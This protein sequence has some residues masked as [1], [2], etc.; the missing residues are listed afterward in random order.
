MLR[1]YILAPYYLIDKNMKIFDAMRACSE[2]SIKF[3]PAIFGLMGVYALIVIGSLITQTIL[4]FA[5]V[6]VLA[7]YYVYYSAPAVRYIQIKAAL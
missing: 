3:S 7:V 6:L 4:G 1:R 2:D 5:Y